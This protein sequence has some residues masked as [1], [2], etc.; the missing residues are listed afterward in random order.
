[1]L[2]RFNRRRPLQTVTGNKVVGSA[3]LKIRQGFSSLAARELVLRSLSAVKWVRGKL[4]NLLGASDASSA[5]RSV[6]MMTFSRLVSDSNAGSSTQ[7]AVAKK[8]A[9][10]LTAPDNQCCADC[11]ARLVDSVWAST[12]FGAFLCIHCAGAHRKLG[13]QLSRVKSLQLD[14]WTEEELLTMRGGNQRVGDVYAK[15]LPQWA[16]SDCSCLLLPDAPHTAREMFVRRKYEELRF[17]KLPSSALPTETANE[18]KGSDSP[19]RPEDSPT[20]SKA[21]SK[22]SDTSPAPA[23]SENKRATAASSPPKARSAKQIKP[24]SVV[25]VTKRFLNYFV[26]IGRGALAPNQ[27]STFLRRFVVW[28]RGSLDSR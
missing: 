20:Q 23:P 16:A 13:V 7:Q 25:E 8:L 11:S 18:E 19:K 14:S 15:Y 6:A 9:E 22:P 21:A 26:V 27:N 24:G 3:R 2:G 12:T 4:G 17:T 10:M 5:S 1:M 28:L